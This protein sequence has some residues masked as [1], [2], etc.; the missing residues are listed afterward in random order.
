MIPLLIGVLVA[1]PAVYFGI[2]C[3]PQRNPPDRT[4]AAFK[5]RIDSER[6]NRRIRRPLGDSCGRGH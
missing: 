3:W 5:R 4:V 1:T 6:V 2:T